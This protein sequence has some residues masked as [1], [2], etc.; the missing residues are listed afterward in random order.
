MLLPWN[1]RSLQTYN[2]AV[3]WAGSSRELFS[4]VASAS[5]DIGFSDTCREGGRAKERERKRE[6]LMVSCKCPVGTQLMCTVWKSSVPDM[7]SEEDSVR[8]LRRRQSDEGR[9]CSS[10]GPVCGSGNEPSSETCGA[11]Q[12]SW[13]WTFAAGRRTSSSSPSQLVPVEEERESVYPSQLVR[14]RRHQQWK[15]HLV[16]PLSALHAGFPLGT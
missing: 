3:E 5:F 16:H 4:I 14:E 13:G 10:C 15:V 8:A 12:V 2:R 1:K 9:C 11:E 6:L 7:W